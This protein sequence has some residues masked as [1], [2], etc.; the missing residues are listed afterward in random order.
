AWTVPPPASPVPLAGTY[1]SRPR[2]WLRSAGSRP[3]AR[4]TSSSTS[5]GRPAG[6]ASSAA[7]T[8]ASAPPR[9]PTPRPKPLPAPPPT[10]PKTA[11]AGELV[12][13][14]TG[15]RVDGIAFP[16]GHQEELVVT[17]P[18]EDLLK[19]GPNDV[20]VELT[21][22]NLPYTLTWSYNTLQPDTAADCPVRLSARL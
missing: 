3:T 12:L 8:A 11:R 17:L 13:R 10:T 6:S 2:P 16:A 5:S 19:P 22:N 7:A 4:P 1:G 9:P 14:V 18:N 21:G 15:K 20:R